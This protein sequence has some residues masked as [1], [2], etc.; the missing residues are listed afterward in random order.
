VREFSLDD[1]LTLL[2]ALST[3]ALGMWLTRRVRLLDAANIPPAVSGGLVV[4]AGL[5]LL[6]TFWG[7]RVTFAGALRSLLLLVF[8][9]SLGLGARLK[10]L[11]RGGPAVALICAATVVVI[12]G[13]NA[14]GVGVAHA[15]G[16]DPR[17]GLFMGSI[18]FLGGH[19]TTAAWSTSPEAA[20]LDGALAL[21][22]ACATFGLI[23]GGLV[24]GPV[25]NLLRP[26]VVPGAPNGSAAV[27]PTPL[28]ERA[29]AAPES[30]D[31]WLRSLLLIAVALGLGELLNRAATAAGFPL[32]GFLTAL[33][34]GV[35]ITNAGD[36]AGRS[37]DLP[38]AELVGTLALRVFLAMII[39][40]VQL[41]ELG[42]LIG[43]LA[44][45]TV[46][47][48]ALT[49]LVAVLIVYP[50]VGRGYE[51]A[52][53]AGGFV[54]FA[55]GAMPVGIG[56]MRRITDRLGPAPHAFLLVSLAASLFQDLAN[57]MLVRAGFWVLGR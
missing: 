25:A 50:A 56:T 13:Q 19:G 52:V 38:R 45:A 27:V 41:T 46:A 47:Q 9:A 16:L 40:G 11:A 55:M 29:I 31:R 28:D 8:F 57:A 21:G 7:V 48:T 20:A 3:I 26:R 44:A 24:G 15:F 2:A 43:P 17:L 4:A 5:A 51:G 35:L 12:V 23:V 18:P 14:V 49:V 34:A 39:L 36:I 54:G 22:I 32:P 33:L 30:S 6:E 53:G 10:L 42:R 37:V 1:P